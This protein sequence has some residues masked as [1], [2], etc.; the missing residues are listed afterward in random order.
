MEI[1]STTLTDLEIFEAAGGRA[2]VFELIARTTTSLGRSALRRRVCNPFSDIT[3][4]RRT[5]EAVAFLARHPDL[6]VVADA[7]VRAVAKY[8]RSNITPPEDFVAGARLERIWWKLRYRDALEEIETGAHA[9][10]KLFEYVAKRCASLQSVDAPASLSEMGSSITGT[11]EEVL[12]VAS[13]SST[14]L[15]MDRPLRSSLKPRIEEALRQ[16]G[17]LDALNAMALTTSKR[18]W[19]FPDLVE[20]DTFLLEAEGL[21]H[22]FL[23]NPVR[24]PVRLSGGEPMVFLTGPNMAGK[25]TYLRSVGLAVLLAQIGMGIPA[26]SARLSP[27]EVLFTS[28]NPSDNLRAGISYFVAE[29]LR[30]RE[31]ATHLAAGKRALIIFDEV[32][33]GTNVHDALDASTEVILGFARARASGCIFSSHLV[34]LVNRLESEPSIRYCCFDAEMEHGIP[35]YSF[36][37]GEGVSD[38]RFGLLLLKQ[39]QVPE[40]IARIAAAS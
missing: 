2:G 36:R 6:V 39:A 33:K 32:F 38:R 31:A 20:S 19:I 40:L 14:L 12:R 4:I 26:S 22:P 13:R 1:D 15:A 23:T 27:A 28:L 16:I 9:T 11:A 29:V 10:V 3:E 34:E 8:L 21:H 37:L 25:T 7:G 5:Q 35:R 24:N 18:G 30:V 17:E